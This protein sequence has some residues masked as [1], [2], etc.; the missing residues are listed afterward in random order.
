MICL[1]A[2]KNTHPGPARMTARHQRRLFSGVFG[3]M[4]RR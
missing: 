2:P 1:I 4:K 3:G